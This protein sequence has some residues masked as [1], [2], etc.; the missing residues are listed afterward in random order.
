[1][2]GPAW[3]NR[4][5]VD[6]A[7]RPTHD[8]TLRGARLLQQ[9]GIPFTAICVVTPDTI[10]RVEELVAFFTELG[11]AC[12]GFN[13]EEQEGSQRTIVDE[14][15]AYQFWRRLVQ[16]RIAGAT[17]PV[18]DLDRLVDHLHRTRTGAPGPGPYD[19]IPTVGHDGRTVLLSPELLGVHS[20]QYG[21]FLAGN[22]LTTPIP[23]MI[24]VAGRLQYVRE[25]ATALHGVRCYLRILRLLSRR[26]GR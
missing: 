6:R 14:D 12:V 22:V 19:P 21:D 24:R 26:T 8:R 10:D 18:R 5:R 9:A 11:C 17:L 15:A 13:I 20:P 4:H 3:A 2:D 16:L 23:Q 1:V 7:R 25:F